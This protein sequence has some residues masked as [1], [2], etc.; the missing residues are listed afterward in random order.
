MIDIR[1]SVVIVEMI[2]MMLAYEAACV[3]PMIAPV[4][5]FSWRMPVVDVMTIR[6]DV[7]VMD[8]E[9]ARRIPVIMFVCSCF[10]YVLD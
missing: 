2:R 1:N 10:F 6:R 3:V 8:R 4:T 5:R 9:I 7:R